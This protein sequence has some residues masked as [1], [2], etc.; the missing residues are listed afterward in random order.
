MEC[1][2]TYVYYEKGERKIYLKT[3]V[4]YKHV[5][6]HSLVCESDIKEVH[7]RKSN[8]LFVKKVGGQKHT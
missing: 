8:T 6:I 3:R 7:D 2:S 4:M 5:Y 1:K